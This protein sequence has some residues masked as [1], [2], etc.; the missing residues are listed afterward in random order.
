MVDYKN[1]ELDFWTTD[2]DRFEKEFD[3]LN[4]VKLYGCDIST[5]RGEDKRYSMSFRNFGGELK[6]PEQTYWQ[7]KNM[8]G[9]D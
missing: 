2:L 6:F 9:D 8:W 3:A 5:D 1:V 4:D 7:F